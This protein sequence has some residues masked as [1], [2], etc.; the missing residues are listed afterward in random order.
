MGGLGIDPAVLPAFILAMALVELTPGPN[1]A[2]LGLLSASR[3]WRAGLQAVAG[4]T[5][6]LSVYLLITLLGLTQT[7]LHSAVGLNL[8][9]WAGI[10]YL[11]WVAWETMRGSPEAASDPHP[12]HGPFVRGLVS[13][14]L[15][16]K[17]AIF[18]LALLPTFIKPAA[19][20]IGA[21]ILTFGAGHILISV[22][23][24]SAAVFGAAGVASRLAPRGALAF[25]LLLAGGL[26]AAALWLAAIPLSTGAAT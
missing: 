22:I 25:R 13:N 7:P 1:L 21:Q 23:I 15:N 9:R 4:I 8:L 11:I 14:L 18:Y 10:A 5:V 6:G 17:A 26:V 3:G 12:A 16:P 19:G 2:Y 24:H 20:S